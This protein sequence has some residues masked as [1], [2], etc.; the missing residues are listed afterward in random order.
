M[1]LV[2][3]T[4]AMICGP[5]NTWWKLAQ[6]TERAAVTERVVS[7][8]IQGDDSSGYHLIETPEGCFTADSWHETKADALETAERRFGVRPSD[9]RP[10]PATHC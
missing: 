8:E 7:L 9:W 6:P 3:V 2:A 1:R 4:K 10:G 5:G